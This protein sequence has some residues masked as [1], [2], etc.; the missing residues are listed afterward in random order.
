[1]KG[2][3]GRL[4]D[5]P[6]LVG[7]PPAGTMQLTQFNAKTQR[8]RGAKKRSS[9][10]SQDDLLFSDIVSAF[11]LTKS[12]GA[13]APLRLCVRIPARGCAFRLRCGARSFPMPR[14]QAKAYKPLI[15][16]SRDS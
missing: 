3:A 14:E 5:R 12:L 11:P 8:R 6:R 10:T 7:P 4:V 13:F 9:Q 1:M 15:E 16:P 2:A